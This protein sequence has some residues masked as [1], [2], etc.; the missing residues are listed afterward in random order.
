R[1]LRARHGVRIREE[2]HD[3][4]FVSLA[5]AHPLEE[6]HEGDAQMFVATHSAAFVIGCVTSGIPV[7][8]VHLTYKDGKARARH[9]S[10]SGIAELAKNGLM[11]S[12]LALDA[13]FHE[14]A[15]VTE[16][17]NDSRAYWRLRA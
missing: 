14:A 8:V 5:L 6:R 4:P 16:S 9:L 2:R 10:T 15:I 12:T 13:I 7:Q 3:E 1:A 17:A 11:R